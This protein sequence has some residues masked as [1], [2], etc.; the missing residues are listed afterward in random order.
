MGTFPTSEEFARALLAIFRGHNVRPGG[1]LLPR[2]V[3][4]QFLTYGGRADDY[5]AALQY[6]EEQGWLELGPNNT[7][8]L[9]Q[10]GF[11]AI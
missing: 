7:L 9:T 6:A 11:D 4:M 10:A 1:V 5:A 8:R 2:Q 3:N